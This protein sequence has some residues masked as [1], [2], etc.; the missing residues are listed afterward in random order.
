VTLP[1]SAPDGTFAYFT[2]NGVLNANT[3][4]YVDATGP[5]NITTAL[6][7]SKR[8]LVVV[9]KRGGSWFANAYVSP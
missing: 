3:V 1:A 7:A 6:T 5:T 4:Q 2:A 9:V 8:H